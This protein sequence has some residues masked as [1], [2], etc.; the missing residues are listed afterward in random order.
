MER[1][2]IITAVQT[3]FDPYDWAAI[4]DKAYAFAR[5]N[6]DTYIYNLLE[7]HS[8]RLQHY[9]EWDAGCE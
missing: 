6:N 5:K 2:D 9:E 4:A 1:Q 7:E 3:I 8:K